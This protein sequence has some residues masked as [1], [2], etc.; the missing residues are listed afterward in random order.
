MYEAK[1]PLQIVSPDKIDHINNLPQLNRKGQDIF[2]ASSNSR[3]VEVCSK[4]RTTF[5]DITF[6]QCSMISSVFTQTP[7]SPMT[8]RWLD[9]PD[10]ELHDICNFA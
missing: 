2:N 7:P 8:K 1:Y 4:S 3:C 5:R 10:S 6:E 9:I